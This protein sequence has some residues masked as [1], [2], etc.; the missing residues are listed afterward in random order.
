MCEQIVVTIPPM[1]QLKK[2]R[3]KPSILTS[4]PHGSPT[5]R[6]RYPVGSVFF[7]MPSPDSQD[8]TAKKEKLWR[9]TG[10]PSFQASG[11]NR[12]VSQNGLNESAP[13]GPSDIF[14]NTPDKQDT[15]YPTRSTT[16]N[17]SQLAVRSRARTTR[18][19][20]LSPRPAII[21]IAERKSMTEKGSPQRHHSSQINYPL[22]SFP[23]FERIKIGDAQDMD[24][25]NKIRS[26]LS[27]RTRRPSANKPSAKSVTWDPAITFVEPQPAI[28]RDL[29]DRPTSGIELKDCIQTIVSLKKNDRHK[30]HRLLDALAKMDGDQ[31]N[32]Q[33]AS[34]I[35][36]GPLNPKAPEF[37][38]TSCFRNHTISE[39]LNDENSWPKVDTLDTPDAM[40]QPVWTSAPPL[41]QT[42][43]TSST[44][45]FR[46]KS[47]PMQPVNRRYVQ[48]VRKSD[49]H[50]V[51]CGSGR[52]AKSID[53]TW[54]NSIL[55]TFT[56]RY[57]LTGHLKMAS[58][59]ESKG[60][61]AAAI[62]QR[63]EFLLLQEKERKAFD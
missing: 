29:V 31:T 38:T 63:L 54:A 26:A 60:R 46:P 53:P 4:N 52:E 59:S 16:V 36:K 30:L 40:L 35:K 8:D 11:N 61:L 17:H 41:V 27:H 2:D 58:P 23:S 18:I 25:E 13:Q 24:L 28:Q 56:A 1:A 39:K 12:S 48:N 21:S 55:E 57:P 51:G 15:L 49:L 47:F 45:D 34:A 43:S 50:Q 62:Q 6:C 14:G 7:D 9:N 20:N 5:R 44:D 32:V 3:A 33:A 22:K 19:P 10:S 37:W 42:S